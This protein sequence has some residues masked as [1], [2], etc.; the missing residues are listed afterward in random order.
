[1]QERCSFFP[2]EQIGFL[3]LCFIIKMV[4]SDFCHFVLLPLTQ[5]NLG[6]CFQGMREK[7]IIL[8]T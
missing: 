3:V 7:K 2:W 6:D 4:L 1:M 5:T 8:G